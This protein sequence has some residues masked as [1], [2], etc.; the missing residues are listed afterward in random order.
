MVNFK[1]DIEFS[2]W[3]NPGA[4]STTD[5][6]ANTVYLSRGILAEIASDSEGVI[7]C[8]G[9]LDEAMFFGTVA[10]Q[11]F[12]YGPRRKAFFV[13]AK[14]RSMMNSWSR[15]K[16]NT[17]VKDTKYGVTINEIDTG[18]GV[19]EVMSAGVFQEIYADADKGIG[20]AL[21]LDRIVRK[22]IE[23][24]D[25]MLETDIQTPGT[26]AKEGQYVSETG[27]SVRSIKHHRVVNNIGA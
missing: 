4:D 24:R 8:G 13:D 7:G 5:A 20:V 15:V 10:E 14:L 22:F 18:H 1:K 25:S 26:D 23:G 21:D 27:F 2:C 17:V 16:L 9:A 19:L 3:M 6:S 12:A 11:I